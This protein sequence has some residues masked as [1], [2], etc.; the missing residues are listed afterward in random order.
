MSAP[1]RWAFL[2]IEAGRGGFGGG[3]KVPRVAWSAPLLVTA[4][5]WAFN[6][7][8][9]KRL[10]A[11]MPPPVVAIARFAIM[12]SLLVA[13]CLAGKQSLRYPKG[14]ALK[15]LGL[16]FL[17][18]G[19]YMVAFLGGMQG[20]TAAEG[21]IVLATSPIFTM[22]VAAAIGKEPFCRASIFGTFLALGGVALIVF[23]GGAST[24]GTLWG[25]GLVLLAAVL[26][27]GSAVTTRILVA[28]MEP[29]R[30]L[31]LCM[32]G[33]LLALLQY[34]GRAA[35]EFDYGT[36]TPTGWWMLG[37]VAILSGVVAFL[38]FYIGV[39]Q[40]GAGRAML[41]Q[42]LVP[43]MAA[44]F[45]W[46]VLGQAM[47]LV[48]LVGLAVVITGVWLAQAAHQRALQGALQKAAG[49]HEV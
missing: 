48:Q 27:A 33:G 17:S 29:L 21:A 7:V 32:P 20:T 24:H 34:G 2:P 11:E 45:G 14:E 49:Y 36:V 10:Y 30:L 5:C 39:K 41:Y 12:E 22:L 26:W 28:D 9:L 19:L 25:N 44:L 16:G 43:G 3:L 23:S 8:A 35:L 13:L 18:M 47:T 6:F 38:G 37:H 42:Y 15:I 40:I 4:V 46:A 31:T 1:A